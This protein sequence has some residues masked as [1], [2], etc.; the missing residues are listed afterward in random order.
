[1]ENGRNEPLCNSIKEE[2]SNHEAQP[3][4]KTME[5]NSEKLGHKSQPEVEIPIVWE[6]GV[7]PQASL[8][9]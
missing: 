1:M 5:K 6:V 7:S 2:I 4:K 8:Q 3:R 9:D